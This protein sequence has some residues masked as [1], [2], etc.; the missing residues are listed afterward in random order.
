MKN[1]T[2][3]Q[4]WLTILTLC[5]GSTTL[6]AMINGRVVGVTDGDT[7]T[8]LIDGHD[9]IKIRLVEIDAPE[10]KQAFGNRSKQSL[11]DLCYNKEAQVDDKGH[12]RY[13]RTLGRVYC[14]GVDTNAAQIK[15]G[16]AWVYDKYVTDRSLYLLQDE[17]RKERRGLWA[18]S[19]PMPPWEW[20]HLKQN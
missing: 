20:R 1:K 14:D 4:S 19:D 5:V 10:K 15:S 9:Q 18:D 3:V 13:G 16:M 17:A 6:A 2:V 12:D 11:S 7:L 8:L